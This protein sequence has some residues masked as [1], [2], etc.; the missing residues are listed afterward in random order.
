MLTTT[1]EPLSCPR[2]SVRK[3][4]DGLV[5][6]S[7][8]SPRHLEDPHLVGRA[9]AIL[10]AAQQP[11]GMETLAFEI[12]HRVHDVL[13]RARAGDRA[14]FGDVTDDTNRYVQTFRSLHEPQRT[15]AHL[16]DAP[17]RGHH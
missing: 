16:A 7:M 13:Q 9:E 2:R 6:S 14:L 11:V 10:D 5:T 15:L 12:Q 1:A 3:S 8:P 4:P 17:R